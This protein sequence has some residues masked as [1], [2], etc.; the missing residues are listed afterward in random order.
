M[1]VALFAVAGPGGPAGTPFFWM[2]AK[3]TGSVQFGFHITVLLSTSYCR[4]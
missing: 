3:F 1:K 2:K 4:C